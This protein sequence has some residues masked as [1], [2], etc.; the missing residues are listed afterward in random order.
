[1]C[2]TYLAI[3]LPILN[4]SSY[5]NAVLPTYIFIYLPTYLSAYPSGRVVGV[6]EWLRGTKLPWV[7]FPAKADRGDQSNGEIAKRQAQRHGAH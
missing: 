6:A 2:G 7:R 5:Q 3:F 1:M 4:H